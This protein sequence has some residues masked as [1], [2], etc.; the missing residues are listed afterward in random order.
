MVPESMEAAKR[1]MA[2]AASHLGQKTKDAGQTI[3]S[4]AQEGKEGTKT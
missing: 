4:K 1:R 2:D 3:Q